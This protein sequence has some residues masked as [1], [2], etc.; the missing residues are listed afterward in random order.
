MMCVAVVGLFVGL[1]SKPLKCDLVFA[2]MH[3]D[4]FFN[5]FI[6]L[7]RTLKT[8]LIS[9]DKNTKFD[10]LCTVMHY[11]FSHLLSEHTI[12]NKRNFT[13]KLQQSHENWVGVNIPATLTS[14]SA[15]KRN[16]IDYYLKKHKHFDLSDFNLKKIRLKFIIIKDHS[17]TCVNNWISSFW[18]G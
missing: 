9:N 4:D 11:L 16:N 17:L 8:Y 3:S 5:L 1:N 18:M 7:P 13:I 2:Y 12:L 10:V 14:R 6:K 15:I